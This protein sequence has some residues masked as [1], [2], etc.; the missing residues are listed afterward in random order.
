MPAHKRKLKSGYMWAYKFEAPGSTRDKRILVRAGGFATRNEAIRAELVRRSEVQ[1]EYEEA[2]RRSAKGLP[3]TLKELLEEYCVR[4]GDKRLEAKTVLRYREMARYL[5][6]ELLAMPIGE[7]T[8][9]HLNRE[10]DRL[11]ESGGHHRRTK[12]PRP[13]SVKTVKNIASLVGAALSIGVFWGLLETNAA[14]HS[15]PPRKT[16]RPKAIALTTAQ[17]DLILGASSHPML[18]LIL[19]LCAASGARRGEVMALRWSDVKEG[20]ATIGRSLSQAAGVVRFKGTK[21]GKSRVVSLPVSTLNF[22]EARRT[23]QGALRQQFGADYRSD[24]DLIVCEPD[25]STLRPD[26]ISS[27]ISALMKR[28]KMPKGVSLHTLRHTHASQLLAAGVDI[29]TI[30]ARLGHSNVR[31]TLEAYSHMLK[32]RDDEAAR[33][34]EAFNKRDEEKSEKAN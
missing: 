10:W 12:L 31:V 21:N 22:L 3:K 18:P 14:T 25:G 4:H 29:A 17:Q 23:E 16:E 15:R 11:V 24:L 8:P 30:S 19:E 27:S 32:G 6:V 9:L 34:W 7:I 1:E 5:S 2:Q 13:L 33:I 20:K 28:L 26:S